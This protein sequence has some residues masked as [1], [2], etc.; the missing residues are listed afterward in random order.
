MSHLHG[1]VE[2]S[3]PKIATG[4]MMLAYFVAGPQNGLTMWLRPDTREYLFP[5]QSNLN[6]IQNSYRDGLH[7]GLDDLKVNRYV[8]QHELSNRWLKGCYIFEWVGEDRL[9]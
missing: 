9:W 7:P 3:L 8:K 5:I 1:E 6:A 2:S 4:Q